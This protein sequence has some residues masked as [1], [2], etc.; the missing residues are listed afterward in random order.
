[1]DLGIRTEEAKGTHVLEKAENNAE[2][3]YYFIAA[4]LQ[5]MPYEA[6]EKL[7]DIVENYLAPVTEVKSER[8]L[9]VNT[10]AV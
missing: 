7:L 2:F 5:E 1:M 8:V 3:L 6:G 9:R 10:F 4:L